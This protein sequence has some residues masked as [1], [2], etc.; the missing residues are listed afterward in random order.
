[1]EFTD[2][3][4]ALAAEAR[5][6]GD[7]AAAKQIAALRKPTRAAWGATRLTP[8]APAPPARPPT[9]PPPRR[10]AQQPKAGPSRRELSAAR[11]PLTEAR[12]GRAL[13]AAGVRAPPAGL[14]EEV[15]ATLTAAL[16]DPDVAAGF[17][18]G[19]LTR[20][21]QWAGFGVA[22]FGGSDDDS[23]PADTL[24]AGEPLP[25][26]GGTWGD[27]S[28]DAGGHRGTA[29]RG[30]ESAAAA[31]PGPLPPAPPRAAPPP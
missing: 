10:P 25:A 23:G 1:Q 21:V 27:W 30:L 16:A 3:R 13:D 18:S 20:A 22:P 7:A 11:G 14:R 8:P 4:K 29:P 19:T 17:A 24:A 9:R 26:Q 2:R 6:A 15:T 5:A 12:P 28:P 31:R